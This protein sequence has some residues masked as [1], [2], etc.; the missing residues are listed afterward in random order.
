M[1]TMRAGLLALGVI[2]TSGCGDDLRYRFD[3]LKQASGESPFI[4]GCN[5]GM[6]PGSNARDMEV[7][8]WLAV[9]PTHPMHLV[10]VWQGDRWST[11]GSNGLVAGISQDGG[12]TWTHTFP[13]LSRCAGGTAAN[14]GGYERSSDPWVTITPD[15]V[16]YAMTISFDSSGD[17]RSAV[18]VSRSGDGGLSWEEP[19]TL[20]ADDNGD[21]FND[22]ES[23]TADPNDATRVYAVWD[24]LTGQLMPTMPIGTGPTWFARTGPGGWEPARAIYDPG[25][26]AQTIGNEIVVLPDGTLVDAF[27]LITNAS[28]DN[29]VFE[30]AAIRSVDQG[31]TWSAP[32]MISPLEAI[33]VKDA[34]AS[35]FVRSAAELPQ[36]AADPAS[37]AVHA[38]WQDA[39]FSN[40]T[41]EG[42]AMSTSTDGGVTWSAPAQVNQDPSTAAFNPAIAVLPD[43]TIG[44]TYD[45][46]RAQ[47][48]ARDEGM[49]V[50]TS[51]LATSHDHGATWTEQALTGGYDLRAAEIGG[52]YFL[53]DYQGLAVSGASFVPFFAVADAAGTDPTNIMVRPLPH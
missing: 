10:G 21:I 44:V 45:D 31:M 3:E 51:F 6:Q 38:I 40:F 36:V 43:G 11:G 19:T 28:S 49:F 22:K 46:M 26:D 52:V 17:P 50:A 9:D 37:G 29:P 1:V 35:V 47:D 18:L 33:G 48:A 2:V 16:V 7:E 12:D 32:V 15:G 13:H 27:N 42:I 20:V 39:R 30:V 53:G 5:G 14:G 41:V 8:P 24:R 25:V 34:S 4:A 23:I